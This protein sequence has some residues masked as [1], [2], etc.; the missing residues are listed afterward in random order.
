[1]G[2]YLNEN[3]SKEEFGRLNEYLHRLEKVIT[4]DVRDIFNSKDSFIWLTLFDR[5]SR[6]SKEDSAFIAF[7]RAFKGG[8]R[9]RAVDG[10]LFDPRISCPLVLTI[11]DSISTCFAPFAIAVQSA[12]LSV[13]TLSLPVFT[14]G[15]RNARITII[16]FVPVDEISSLMLS[17]ELWPRLTIDI[18]DAMPMIMPNIVSMARVLFLI[19]AAY[20]IFKRL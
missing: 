20:A 12:F 10:Q 2:I 14:P 7:L 16:M 9:N 3:S 4:E 15:R 5:F 11:G 13:C 6:L 8:L 19:S 1:M 18:T 17:C